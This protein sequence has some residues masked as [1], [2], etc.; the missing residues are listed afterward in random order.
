MKRIVASVGLVAVGASGLQ[1]GLLPAMTAE[2]GK[3]WTVSATLRG[4]Y[5]D[6]YNTIPNDAVLGPGQFRGSYGWEVSPALM[7]NLPMEQTT[8]SFGYVYSF[9]YYQHKPLNS[10]E[11]YD[12]TSDL[13]FGLT[14]AFNERY[15]ISIKDSYV[16]GQE[17]DLLRAGNTYTTFQ[18][19]PGNNQRNFASLDFLAQLTPEF[20]VQV[21]YNNTLYM[22]ADNQFGLTAPPQ[23]QVVTSTAGLMNE[24]QQVVHI[25]GRYQLQPQTIGIVG[26]QGRANDYT[27]DQPIW[28]DY[29]S[30]PV[31]GKVVKSDARNVRAI[32]GYLGADH[33]F[34][35]DLTGSIRLGGY[36]SDYY[37][38]PTSQNNAAPYGTLSLQYTYLPESYVQFGASADYSESS[39][40]APSANNGALT[41]NAQSF[42][43]YVT[44]R[45]RIT[46]KL[47]GG[48]IAQFQNS[49]YY[50][51]AINSDTDRY[52]LAG[53][54]LQY[55]FTPNFSAEAGYNFDYLDSQVG[56]TYGRNRVYL[57][58]TG[59][60]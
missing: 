59:S 34:R 44:L 5:D 30:D 46:P 37:N 21:G 28:I 38:D 26:V 52:Y 53:L 48:V 42:T 17:P 18:R 1:A 29:S 14:H 31:N 33:N 11:Y 32:Y 27:A 36:Y 4:F 35:P 55:R 41:L 8:I 24:M 43:V 51:G 56:N 58:V 23:P 49:R 6:N 9:K 7:V 40:F 60:Y 54:N 25:D 10:T 22:Y 16:I 47:F 39:A 15:S 3:P 12:Q 13:N 19:I 45:H 2:T 57:G 20:G 50:G